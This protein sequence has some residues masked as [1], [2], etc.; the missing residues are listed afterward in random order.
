MKITRFN[1]CVIFLLFNI[2]ASSQ[3][4]EISLTE[5]WANGAWQNYSKTTN[6]LD[7]NGNITNQLIQNWEIE[8]STWDDW[9][10]ATYSNTYSGFPSIIVYERWQN[11]SWQDYTQYVYNYDS[12]NN[13]TNLLI[14][15]WNTDSSEWTDLMQ[16]N[17]SYNSS[18]LL[19][20]VLYQI[21]NNGSWT[22][23][24]RTNYTYGSSDVLLTL[25]TEIWSNGAWQNNSNQ[26]Y[27]YD[28]NN[29]LTYLFTQN[30]DSAS[31]S[32][33]N[34]QQSN[35]TN[36][37][38]GTPNQV[39][40]QMLNIPSNTWYN[41]QR[42]TYTYPDV[43]SNIQN[44]SSDASITIY[45]IPTSDFINVNLDELRLNQPFFISDYIGR[46]LES[47]ILSSGIST[48]DIHH[49]PAGIYLMNIDDRTF[50]IVKQ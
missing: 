34:S 3:N 25:V 10:R 14:Q 49:L 39:I 5:R 33:I 30:W 6:S 31:A 18:G 9:L 11:G 12:N 46:K 27:S 32:W 41:F 19:E 47:G 17:Y 45:P 2:V 7:Q 48:I 36:N 26:T 16:S 28:A 50:R 42:T 43:N 44:F 29:Y 8:S 22:N 15:F 37:E 38:D 21:L 23:S 1:L 40:L 35:Y 20:G 4:F 24:S 13:L